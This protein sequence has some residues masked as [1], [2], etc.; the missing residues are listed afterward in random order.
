ME[1]REKRMLGTLILKEIHDTIINL[2]FL[3]A[4]LLCLILIPLGMYVTLQDYNQRLNDYNSSQQLYLQRSEGQINPRFNAE[5]YRP[6]SPLS[7]FAEG[8]GL[9]LPNK[10]VTSRR[11]GVHRSRSSIEGIVN[12]SNNTK[13]KSPLSVLFGKIDFVFNVGFVL[14]IF[15]LIFTFAGITSEK[16]QGTLKLIMANPVPRWS[17]LLAKIIGNYVVFIIPFLISFLISIIILNLSG[18]FPM[19]DSGILSAII[20]ILAVTVLFLFC[21]F[22]FGML[23]SSSMQNSITSIITVLFIWVLFVLVIPKLSPMI[24]QIIHPVES[25]E[26]L[27]NMIQNTRANIEDELVAKE[28]DL[29]K[30]L[31]ERYGLTMDTFFQ[32]DERNKIETEFDESV[33]GIREEYGGRLT[34]ETIRLQRNH[35]NEKNIQNNFALQLSRIS[36][37]S[38]YIY[39]ITEL[40]GTGISEVVNFT[41]TAERFQE[42]VTED[43]YDQYTYRQYGTGGRYNSGF[44][45]NDSFDPSKL[46][47]PQIANYSFLTVSEVIGEEWIDILL[48]ALYSILFFAGSFV[49]FLRYDVR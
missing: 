11:G 29:F 41:R 24:A 4:S 3:I 36:P 33:I 8:L 17:I 21:M 20:M 31:L 40:A 14:S 45:K 15:A 22:T 37:I 2:R 23:I 25:E 7:V 18:I 30:S 10:A 48:L 32:A 38:C 1:K 16:E 28:D 9:F 46:P 27:T 19:A 34:D 42:Q 44:Y 43:V 49:K 13:P 26:V 47:V 39:I 35:D 12:I 5:G 6:P